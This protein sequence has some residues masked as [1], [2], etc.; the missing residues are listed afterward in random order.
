MVN[1]NYVKKNFFYYVKMYYTHIYT[2]R[3]KQ[4]ET[5]TKLS[6]RPGDSG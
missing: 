2:Q 6:V 3:M 1:Y 5:M 4:Y